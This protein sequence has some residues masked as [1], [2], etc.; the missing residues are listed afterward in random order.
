MGK[1]EIR[2]LKEQLDSSES[3]LK[4]KSRFYDKSE[5]ERRESERKRHRIEIEFKNL[6]NEIENLKNSNYQNSGN[7]N[8]GLTESYFEKMAKKESL[9]LPDHEDRDH[10]IEYILTTGQHQNSSDI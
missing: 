5:A 6:K 9:I 2:S 4:I 3:L 1:T 10:F 8:N 7:I